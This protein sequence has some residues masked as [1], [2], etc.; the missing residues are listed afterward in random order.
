MGEYIQIRIDLFSCLIYR[1]KSK[2]K[3]APVSM[4][5]LDDIEKFLKTPP[6]VLTRSQSMEKMPV[7]VARELR[8]PG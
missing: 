6:N 3:R 2:R 8:V 7:V 4:G 5:R 1:K